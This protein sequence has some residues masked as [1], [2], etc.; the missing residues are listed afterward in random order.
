MCI[1]SS[2]V[3]ITCFFFYF[4]FFINFICRLRFGFDC[5]AMLFCAPCEQLYVF[6]IDSFELN[7]R[8]T[9][10]MNGMMFMF[11]T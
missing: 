4:F 6:M 1:G 5:I 7:A 2:C 3:V 8:V 11:F 10:R 9:D